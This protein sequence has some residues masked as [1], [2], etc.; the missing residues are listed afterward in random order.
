MVSLIILL[1][2]R[3]LEIPGNLWNCYD[4]HSCL[5][6]FATG[7]TFFIRKRKSKN[8]EEN[9]GVGDRR[10]RFYLKCISLATKIASISVE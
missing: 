4:K 3:R 1:F 9:A 10:L 8:W 6:I 7:K 5:K 2:L